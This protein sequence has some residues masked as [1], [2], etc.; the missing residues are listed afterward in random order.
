MK[1]AA[2]A[3]DLLKL[4]DALRG[5]APGSVCSQASLTS[6][7]YDTADRALRRHGLVLRVREAAGRFVQTVKADG[8][9]VLTRGEWED[10]IA[11]AAPDFRAPRSGGR[12][13]PEVAGDLRPLFATAVTR[14][15]ILLEA[16]PSV[17]IEAAIDEGEIR[18]PDGT[19]VTPISEIEL[20]LK[21]GEP[22]ALFD[23]AL[24]LLA[25][26]PLRIETRSKAER[27]YAAADGAAPA[28][29]V[30]AA[31]ISLDPAISVEEALQRIGRACLAHLLRNQAASLAGDPGGLHQMRVASRRL[32]SMVSSLKEA[33]PADGRR[34][35]SGELKRLD[36]ILG[37]ARNL[38]VFAEG[39]LPPV[40][41]ATPG[42]P[43]L[44]PLAQALDAARR[45]AAERVAAL[46]RSPDFTATALRLL[47]WFEARGWR[48]EASGCPDLLAQPIGEAAPRLLDRGLRKMRRRGRGFRHADARRRHK[49]RI[50][51]KELRYTAELLAGLFDRRQVERFV[52]RVKALQDGLGYAHDVQV[53]RDLVADL[54]AQ[55]SDEEAVAAAGAHVLG[56]HEH[57]VWAAE[58]KL[59]KRLRRLKRAEPYWRAAFSARTPDGTSAAAPD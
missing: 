54:G 43:A 35:V 23:V 47:R 56:W 29:P 37:P 18:G 13:P 17:C 2:A 53:G 16:A 7:Y 9:D 11:G 55:A 46:I 5:L 50:A 20:E 58:R 32:R 6:T 3:C 59:R 21:Q 10:E 14:T 51:L 49:L 48:E 44:D 31:P 26:A 36:A 45:S 40:R 34:W 41:A 24:A 38:D 27:G 39:L 22:G 25:T 33:L 42:G 4:R 8:A 1:L 52:R 12:L 28:R 19:R 15:A 30:H 57:A